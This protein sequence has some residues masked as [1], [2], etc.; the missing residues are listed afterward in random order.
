MIPCK[1]GKCKRRYSRAHRP[2]RYKL[3]RWRKCENKRCG[4]NLYVDDY[5]YRG[6]DP[7]RKACFCDHYP[8][9][10]RKGSLYCVH[11]RMGTQ[12]IPFYMKGTSLA[13]TMK[14]EME[15]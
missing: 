1:C 2:E 9:P 7:T 12:G 14:Q 5:R 8:F 11:G 4:G 3:D 13:M 6:K 10:H 15:R